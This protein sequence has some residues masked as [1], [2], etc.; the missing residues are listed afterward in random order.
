[1]S[2]INIA[3]SSDYKYCGKHSCASSNAGHLRDSCD[4]YDLKACPTGY[5]NVGFPV[6]VED[7]YCGP[8]T[9]FDDGVVRQC[10]RDYTQG[11]YWDPL[12]TAIASQGY[13]P[14]NIEKANNCC[15]GVV[16]TNAGKKECGSLLWSGSGSK[17]QTCNSVFKMWCKDKNNILDPKCTKTIAADPNYFDLKGLCKTKEPGSKW[18]KVCSCHYKHDFYAK[19]NKKIGDLWN[20]PHEFLNANPECM[21]PQCTASPYA[22]KNVTCPPT[23]FTKCVQNSNVVLNDS[24]VEKV[25]I[26]QSS[27]CLHFTTK[28]KYNSSNKKPPPPPPPPPAKRKDNKSDKETNEEE[29]LEK[30]LIGGGLV[31]FIIF[32]SLSIYAVIINI[33]AKSKS[34]DKYLVKPDNVTLNSY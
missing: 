2:N 19:L 20:V 12:P 14:S 10:D 28:K 4:A 23:S 26:K 22:N 29:N 13:T 9:R 27:D 5:K 33:G 6:S 25:D 17:P 31:M 24:N 11:T 1:M 34:S 3:G 8:G 15:S 7:S 21:F 16:Y 32:L 18:D 30:W